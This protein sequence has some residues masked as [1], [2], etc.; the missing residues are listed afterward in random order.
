VRVV[1]AETGP[2]TES[3]RVREIDDDEGR[4][5]LRATCTRTGGVRHL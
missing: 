1:E 3:L 5:R 4:R 2:V